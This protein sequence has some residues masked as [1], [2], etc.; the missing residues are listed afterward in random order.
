MSEKSTE[1]V[2]QHL[3]QVFPIWNAKLVRPFKESL[4]KEMSLETY[5]CLETIKYHGEMTMSQL[6]AKLKVPKQQ[7]TK[8]IDRLSEHHFV[9]RVHDTADRRTI[10]IRLTS[11]ALVYLDDY[12][13]KNHEFIGYLEDRLTTQELE[14]MNDAVLTLKE[15]LL[16]LDS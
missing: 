9:E 3:L 8:L 6:A 7:V 1:A 11:D 15:I 14:R 5:Y 4:K 10:W 12:Y 13:K 16:K 2:V